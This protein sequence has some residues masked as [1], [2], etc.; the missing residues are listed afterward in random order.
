MS[1][2]DSRKRLVEQALAMAPHIA[3]L[4]IRLESFAPSRA[5]MRLPYAEDL[6]AYRETGVL[7]GGAVY[8]LMDS[9]CGMAVLAALKTLRPVAT[10]D[11]RL[12]YMKPAA[13]GRDLFGAADCMKVTRHIAF[14]RGIAYHE[15]EDD[16]IAH[17]TATFALRN[18]SETSEIPQ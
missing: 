13:R 16:P 14:V 18:D 6:I 4:G 12:D 7:A 9:V 5:V 10:L 1:E 3:A 15:R 8:S 11:L 17:A 2:F